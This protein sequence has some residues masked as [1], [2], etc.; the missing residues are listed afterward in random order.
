MTLGVAVLLYS[1]VVTRY[2][3]LNT[4]EDLWER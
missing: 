3:G 2:Q 1:K 4:L